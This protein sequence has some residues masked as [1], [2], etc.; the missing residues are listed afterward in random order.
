MAQQINLFS[1]LY[2][3]QKKYFSAGTMARALGLFAAAGLVL[4]AYAAFQTRSLERLSRQA[5]AALKSEREQLIALGGS[6]AAQGRS[7]ALQDEAERL[8]FKLK[9]REVLLAS[10]L[11]QAGT[12]NS[13]YS[14]YLVALARRGTPGVWLTDVAISSGGETLTLKGRALGAER[15]PAYMSVLKHEPAI[16]GRKVSE[17]VLAAKEAQK[18]DPEPRIEQFVEFTMSLSAPASAQR[19]SSKGAS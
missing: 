11:A 15:V 4:Y 7:K 19:K 2:L 3:R 6:L 16:Q 13:A 9:Q 17:L 18:S 8:E 12:E 5:D 10:L 1:P 14:P